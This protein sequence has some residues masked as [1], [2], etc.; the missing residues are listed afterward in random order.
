MHQHEIPSDPRTD[1][2]SDEDRPVK[3]R[4]FCDVNLRA[5]GGDVCF[6]VAAFKSKL[7]EYHNNVPE[8]T[9]SYPDN[10]RF[11]NHISHCVAGQNRRRPWSYSQLFFQLPLY[12]HHYSSASLSLSR[13]LVEV[14]DFFKDELSDL[15]SEEE[16]QEEPEPLG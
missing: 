6:I 16:T 3:N 1:F 14:E 8:V 12:P 9:I 4:G 15:D 11:C 7:L 13:Q 2:F 5:Q 10:I